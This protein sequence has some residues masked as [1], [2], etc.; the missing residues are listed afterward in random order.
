MDSH[1]IDVLGLRYEIQFRKYGTDKALENADGYCDHT[2]KLI[3]VQ[4]GPDDPNNPSNL[5]NDEVYMKQVLRHEIVHAFHLEA[6][7]QGSFTPIGTGIPESIVD[8]FAI[9]GPRIYQAW[10]EADAL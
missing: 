7:L 5:G 10:K 9:M 8:W 4:E 6:G 3:V 1:Y 2:L